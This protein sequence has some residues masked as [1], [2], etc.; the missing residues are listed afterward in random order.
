MKIVTLFQ[1][2]VDL[3]YDEFAFLVLLTGLV[4]LCVGPSH[5][6]FAA[7]AKDITY[8]MESR[9]QHPVLRGADNNIDTVFKEVRTTWV[10][11]VVR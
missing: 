2:E 3:L 5:H 11:P 4:R 8:T 6:L 10:E 7:F 1:M 9:D